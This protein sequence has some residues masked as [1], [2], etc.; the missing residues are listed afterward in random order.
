MATQSVM[1]AFMEGNPVSPR[2]IA[3]RFK[4]I[5][6]NVSVIQYYAPTNGDNKEA[7]SKCV[8]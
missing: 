3:A 8:R 6:R 1:K 7:I 5:G 4:S 2:I